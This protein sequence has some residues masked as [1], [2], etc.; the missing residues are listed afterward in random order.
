AAGAGCQPSPRVD[1]EFLAVAP[2]RLQHP[3]PGEHAQ[4]SQ[5]D[6]VQGHVRASFAAA[7]QASATRTAS[8][9]PG[10]SC[11]REHQAPVAAASA[12]TAT[13]ASSEL[14]KD[15]GVPSGAASSLPRKRL[16]DAPTSTGNSCPT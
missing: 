6:P 11:T 13:V 14:A 7:R 4:P 9:L 8:E 5:D 2:L 16:R 12:V 10:T 15:R 3:V 1:P